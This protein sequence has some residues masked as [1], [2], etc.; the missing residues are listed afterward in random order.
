MIHASSVVVSD[1][2]ASVAVR[3]AAIVPIKSVAK[4]RQLGSWMRTTGATSGPVHD[5]VGGRVSRPFG[6]RPRD[7]R[8]DARV[9]A[10]RLTREN[11]SGRSE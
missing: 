10:S 9:R 11:V 5:A 1:G 4:G 2:D 3:P 8:F 7:W 6:S